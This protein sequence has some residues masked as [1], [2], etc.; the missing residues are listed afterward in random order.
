MSLVIRKPAENRFAKALVF[1]PAG[2]G[3][4]VF[5]GS[6]DLDERT[7][8]MLLLDFEGG[9]ESLA[10]LDVDVAEIHSW[11][12]YNE[13]YELLASKDHGYKSVGLDSITETHKWALLKIIGRKGPSRSEPDLIEQG[14][15]GIGT[16]Q[17]RRLLREFRDLPM[18]VFFSAHSK[19]VEYPREGKVRVPD[20][21]GQMAEEVSGIVSIQ[22]YLA[23]YEEE[24][25]THR[26]LLLHSFP[27]FRIK[28]R[29]PWE[30]EVPSELVDPTVTTLL[31]ALGYQATN[32]QVVVQKSSSPV[33]DPVVDP[34]PEVQPEEEPEQEPEPQPE[35][36]PEV[37]P[38]DQET[39]DS[40]SDMTLPQL[41]SHAREMGV[42][43]VGLRNRTQIV[44]KILAQKEESNGSGN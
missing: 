19:E 34:E 29:T 10:G 35:E 23:Q 42:S 13:A 30:T 9:S 22:G 18:H 4:T 21:V 12:D 1:A 20:L 24:G 11:E 25:A 6:A 33:V 27:R 2:A 41:R 40:Y 5:L 38:V 32:G 31:D 37:Q 26:T 8:P 17:M 3:K 15:Y 28:A 44:E 7:A 36:E 14:D 16:T 39:L 43:L